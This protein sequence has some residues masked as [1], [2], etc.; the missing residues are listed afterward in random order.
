[1]ARKI[2]LISEESDFFEYIRQKLE[3]R[4]SDELFAFSFDSLP[5]KLPFLNS[6]LF[7]INSENSEDKTLDL[8]KLLN[9]TPSIVF[10][11]N[12]DEVFRR[13]CYR[14]GMFDFMTILTPDAEFRARIIPA[15]T[16]AS[17][18][19]K[20]N[21]YREILVNDKYLMQHNEVFLN[22]EK[23]LDKEL[24]EINQGKKNAVFAAIAPNEKTKFLL[25]QNAIE[26][27]ILENIRRNDVLMNYAPNKYFLLLY[28][29]NIK[30]AQDLWQK[31]N[32]KLPQ[33]IYAGFVNVLSQKR[34]QLINEALNK[35]HEAINNDKNI[36]VS[37]T[38]NGIE[39]YT[40]FKQFRQEFSKKFE[41]IV[42]PVFYQIQQ[43]Y[44]GKFYGISLQQEISEG[45][46]TFLIKSN[47]AVSSFKITSAGFSKI[48]V[49]ITFQKNV[50]SIDA[51]RITLDSDEFESGLLED[52]LEQFILEYKKECDYDNK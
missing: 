18:L 52:L 9:A 39:N 27:I 37:N 35:L 45:V 1:M 17:I 24:D 5:E 47:S 28:D 29:T 23:I 3:L 2:V 25:T 32:D 30:S 7:I 46:G 20:N 44:S 14:A 42:T 48:N 26:T 13:K 40:N 6:A 16:V 8:L 21:Q 12:E 41:Q 49:D 4:K 36:P 10:S 11:F 15:L 33:R 34:Q 38:I 22:Y 50:D 31:I 19:E 51:K 43:K